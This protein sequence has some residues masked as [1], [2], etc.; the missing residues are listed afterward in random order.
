MSW[1]IIIIY[2]FFKNLLSPLLAILKLIFSS[3]ILPP[4]KHT[5]AS[6][7]QKWATSLKSC[8]LMQNAN[9][10]VFLESDIFTQQHS[11]HTHTH[12]HRSWDC[13]SSFIWLSL[14]TDAIIRQLPV[15]TSLLLQHE[16]L[17]LSLLSSLLPLYS[18]DCKYTSFQQNRFSLTCILHWL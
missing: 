18:Y 8:V 5:G 9:H 4:Y 16:T 2:I 10:F 14:Y 15:H 7:S 3:N 17:R 11:T 13:I 12:T 6:L 1:I